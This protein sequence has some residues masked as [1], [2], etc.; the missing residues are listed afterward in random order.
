M[1]QVVL[2]EGYYRK[3]LSFYENSLKRVG[4][5]GEKRGRDEEDESPARPA[6]G[7]VLHVTKVFETRRLFS[8][9]WHKDFWINPFSLDWP[10]FFFL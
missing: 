8:Q 1:F 6:A 9:P 5:R 2:K 10:M 7:L 3:S 4:A